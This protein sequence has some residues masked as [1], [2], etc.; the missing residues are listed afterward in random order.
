MIRVPAADAPWLPQ[1]ETLNERARC[2]AGHKAAAA[3]HRRWRDARLQDA[4]SELRTPSPIPIKKRETGSDDEAA[5]TRTMG[6]QAHE[7]DGSCRNDRGAHRLCR[8]RGPLGP[9]ADAIRAALH[10]A[11]RRCAADRGGDRDAA[12]RAGRWRSAGARRSRSPARHRLRNPKGS[13]GVHTAAR[14]LH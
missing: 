2:G 12:D 14:G 13:A 6:A 4:G 8:R 11:P 3:R 7:R 10:A 5:T 1:M 9:S